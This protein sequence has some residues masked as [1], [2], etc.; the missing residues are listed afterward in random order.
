MLAFPHKAQ[1]FL[2]IAYLSA[3]KLSALP[4]MGNNYQNLIYKMVNYVIWSN[5]KETCG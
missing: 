5:M 2:E 3:H 4:I 1:R